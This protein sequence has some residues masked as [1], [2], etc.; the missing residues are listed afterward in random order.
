MKNN[1]HARP[2]ETNNSLIGKRGSARVKAKL[3][4]RVEQS[5]AE[6]TGASATQDRP[7]CVDAVHRFGKHSGST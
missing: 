7:S 3:V 5:P 2:I 1:K 4:D 6:K